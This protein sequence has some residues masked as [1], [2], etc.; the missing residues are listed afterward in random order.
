M[1]M[2]DHST[3][4]IRDRQS[5]VR[6]W[7]YFHTAAVAAAILSPR[8][9]SSM[10]ALLDAAVSIFACLTICL[11]LVGPLAVTLCVLRSTLS[12]PRGSAVILVE[13]FITYV[14]LLTPGIA[15]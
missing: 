14:H 4:Q 5:F 6:F 8:I 10:S 2:T 1:D 15:D 9:G 7:L 12:L 3:H 13:L 11:R